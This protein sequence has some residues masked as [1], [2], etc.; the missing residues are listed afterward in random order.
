MA[1]KIS[2]YATVSN[3]EAIAEAY[4]DVKCNGGK[5]KAESKAIIET[6]NKYLK[7]K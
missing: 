4:S 1:R 6:L 7:K 2:R 3:A 5:A